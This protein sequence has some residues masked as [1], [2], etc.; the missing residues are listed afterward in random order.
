MEKEAQEYVLRSSFTTKDGRT[1]YASWYGKKCF[2][3]PVKAKTA[4]V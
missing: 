4:K 2:R 3:I 1:I